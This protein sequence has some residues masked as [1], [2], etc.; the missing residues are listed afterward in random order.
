MA[1]V[2]DVVIRAQGLT[3][4]FGDF[5]AVDNLSFTVRAGEVVGYLGP[6]GSGKTTTIRMLL[7]LLLPC[8]GEAQVLGYDAKSQSEQVRER[9]GYMSQKFS[10]YRELTV[11][12]NLSFSAG[13]YGIRDK[14]RLQGIGLGR[15][16]WA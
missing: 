12:E 16:V 6:N 13:V 3:R 5:L 11:G 1:P 8:D 15:I 14:G 7:G 2:S 10:L 9:V 4:Y